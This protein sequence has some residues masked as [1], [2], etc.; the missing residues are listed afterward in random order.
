MDRAGGGDEGALSRRETSATEHTLAARLGGFILDL[1]RGSGSRD[2][3]SQSAIA[4]D[5]EALAHFAVRCSIGDGG[6][7]AIGPVRPRTRV[8]ASLAA[9]I[10]RM[11]TK[12]ALLFRS[13]M[14]RL[15]I[16]RRVDFYAGFT[17]L[18]A[19]LFGD[20]VNWSKIVALYA[21]G[22]RLGKATRVA[23]IKYLS[24]IFFLMFD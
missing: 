12:H 2:P 9:C 20:E 14:D 1:G 8:E 4:E 22:A 11:H 23:Q 3:S 13:M 15:H 21:F 18:A 16:N 5:S 10:R 7:P 17:E 19:D 24:N 6:E